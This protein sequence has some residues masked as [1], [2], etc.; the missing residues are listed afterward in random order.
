MVGQSLC[1]V[2]MSRKNSFSTI[3]ELLL[4]LCGGGVLI[5]ASACTPLSENA[6]RSK[7]IRTA[8]QLIAL[9]KPSVAHEVLR[10]LEGDWCVEWRP[11]VEG[12]AVSE[13]SGG[14]SEIS[15]VM[16]GRF[17]EE[18]FQGVLAGKPFEWRNFIGFNNAVG[19]YEG[20][21][22][23]SLGTG[24]TLT[25]G[26]FDKESD[27]IFF[28]GSVYNPVSEKSEHTR[29]KLVFIREDALSLFVKSEED[30]K[31]N[32][33]SLEVRYNRARPEERSDNSTMNLKNRTVVCAQS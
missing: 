2:R 25:K 13:L 22:M 27:T 6:G 24:M 20:V 18:R 7:R 10:R 28:V 11:A 26:R 15:S 8:E 31:H 9:N 4:L 12:G 16:D 32:R 1:E 3:R 19:L 33:I 30:S 29:S 17:I 14:F 23:D 5:V 21:W